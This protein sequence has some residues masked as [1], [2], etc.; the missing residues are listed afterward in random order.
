MRRRKDRRC[1]FRKGIPYRADGIEIRADGGRLAGL[2]QNFKLRIVSASC[3]LKQVTTGGNVLK[4]S[5]A[6]R[7]DT[8]TIEDNIL[9]CRGMPDENSSS[10]LAELDVYFY[11]LTFDNL[12]FYGTEK[13]A[14]PG[15][16]CKFFLCAHLQEEIV[17]L[18]RQKRQNHHRCLN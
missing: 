13:T 1:V 9:V 4:E 14:C 8:L 6:D 2:N 10:F 5:V 3:K 18:T 11:D 16:D 15:F 7:A 12:G 17:L